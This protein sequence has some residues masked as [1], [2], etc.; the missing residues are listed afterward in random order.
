MLAIAILLTLLLVSLTARTLYIWNRLR[1]VP[2]PFSTGFSK[3]WLLKRT[4]NGTIHME[5]A[6]ATFDHG[7]VTQVRCRTTIRESP[8]TLRN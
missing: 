5:T 1:H 7:E 6:Q 3:W 4:L 2:G 8:P